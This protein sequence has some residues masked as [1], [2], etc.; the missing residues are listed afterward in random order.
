MPKRADAATTAHAAAWR[1]DW[2]RSARASPSARAR[3]AYFR[4]RLRSPTWRD[5]R[6]LFSQPPTAWRRSQSWLVSAA[7]AARATEAA[8]APGARVTAAA[9]VRP[10]ERRPRPAGATGRF[11]SCARGNAEVIVW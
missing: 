2:S 1:G 5:W 3:W 9:A 10:V 7:R 6:G 4:A 8:G 11:G